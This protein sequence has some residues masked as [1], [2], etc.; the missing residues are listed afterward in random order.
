MG[1]LRAARSAKRETEKLEGDL[2]S[3][4]A[5]FKRIGREGAGLR[6]DVEELVRAY[7]EKYGCDPCVELQTIENALA[8]LTTDAQGPAWRRICKIENEISNLE[9]RAERAWAGVA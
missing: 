1:S 6:G 8:S 4:H 2:N 5:D 7:A 9:E 3:A